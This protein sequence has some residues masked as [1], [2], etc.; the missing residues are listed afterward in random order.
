MR[1]LFPFV[2]VVHCLNAILQGCNTLL[3][4]K[5]R[6]KVTLGLDSPG[7]KRSPLC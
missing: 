4:I 3:C 1:T 7:Y 5:D 2:P 6:N